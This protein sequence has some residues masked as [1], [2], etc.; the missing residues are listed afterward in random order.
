MASLCTGLIYDNIE[1]IMRVP[2]GAKLSVPGNSFPADRDRAYV[3]TRILCV[4]NAGYLPPGHPDR[5]PFE[6]S[7]SE[8]ILSINRRAQYRCAVGASMDAF[9]AAS[10]SPHKDQIK[11]LQGLFDHLTAAIKVETNTANILALGE[12]LKVAQGAHEEYL[13]TVTPSLSQPIGISAHDEFVI[14]HCKSTSDG[15]WGHVMLEELEIE[16][17]LMDVIPLC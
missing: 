17:R 10:H 8:I 14:E 2:T 1:R 13:K 12:A 16:L 5:R 4:P 11:K 7:D 15:S 3:L 6:G 9:H